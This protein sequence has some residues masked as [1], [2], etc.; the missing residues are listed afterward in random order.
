MSQVLGP[1]ALPFG[2]PTSNHCGMQQVEINAA[3]LRRLEAML[4]P[5]RAANLQATAVRARA[6]FGDRVV[7]HVSATATGG[8]VAE[9]LQTLLAYAQGAGIE[10]RWLVLD[11]DPDFFTITKRIHNRLHGDPGDG[12][13]LAAPER[14]HYAAV[15]AANLTEM[16]TRV[17][18]GDIVLLHDPQT[19]GLA[20]GLRSNGLHVAWRCHVGRD[21]PT[22]LATS[23]W[24]F[25]RP[26]LAPVES[27]VFSRRA[28]APAWVDPDCL[29]VIPPSI[30]PFSAKNAELSSQR[31]EAILATVGLVSGGHPEEGLQFL[32]RDG[33][34]GTIRAL[35]HDG[36]HPVLDGEPPPHNA[37]LVLQVS[38]WDRLK[39]MAGVMAGFA[40]MASDRPGDRTHLMLAGPAV[41]GVSDDPEGAEVLAECR[42]QWRELPPDIRGRVHL[43][44]IPLDDVDQNAIIVN[45]LQR[46]AFT[47]VQKSL[48]EG[49]GLTVTEAMW[50][51]RPVIASKVGGIQDQ[52]VDERDGL[53]VENPQDLKSFAATLGRLLDDPDLASRLGSAGRVRVMSDFL[54][55]RHL[56]QYVELFSQLVATPEPVG[57]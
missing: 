10:N 29:F 9:M 2:R 35:S 12:G 6:S 46:H 18:P 55:D 20:E 27:Y 47:V 57:A 53:L 25:L 38:R 19:A 36:G 32:R 26:F 40:L 28:Y 37:R 43:A 44:A 16:L 52:I 42:Q 8:G 11:A 48:M 56:E 31:V 3:P 13:P 54:G 45:A 34:A 4:S 33:S 39:D 51:G 1:I 23:A 30:D 22:E 7:W 50:K 41:T 49:F 5:Q 21:D 17:S 24:D 15:L 14:A